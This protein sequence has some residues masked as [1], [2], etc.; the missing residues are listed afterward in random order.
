MVRSVG[1]AVRCPVR[2][3]VWVR[4]VKVLVTLCYPLSQGL[5]FLLEGLDGQQVDLSIKMSLWILTQEQLQV[6]QRTC[7][8]DVMKWKHLLHYWPFVRGIHKNPPNQGPVIW[9]LM[10]SFCSGESTVAKG[11]VMVIW[12]AYCWCDVTL[13]CAFRTCC[14]CMCVSMYFSMMESSDKEVI[15]LNWTELMDKG[16][17]IIRD[18]YVVT[19]DH[20]DKYKIAS[21]KQ[22]MNQWNLNI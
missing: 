19:T 20:Q 14:V 22:L 16:I 11:R 12:D 2:W 15:G 4:D 6:Q 5:Q 7:H 10:L 9:R 1:D 8:H 3:E 18:A 17:Y 21:E 13:K